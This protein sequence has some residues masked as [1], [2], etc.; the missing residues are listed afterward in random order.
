MADSSETAHLVPSGFRDKS[1]G[2]QQGLKG[3]GV[4]PPAV[5]DFVG[6][7]VFLDVKIVD[8]RNRELAAPGRL[9]SA[10]QR[11]PGER[12]TPCRN[13]LCTNSTCGANLPRN[14]R[15]VRS[16]ALCGPEKYLPG[17][18]ECRPCAAVRIAP[19]FSFH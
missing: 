13:L 3:A 9:V 10:K 6:Q 11:P 12:A 19:G 4:G 16:Q 8:V 7:F 18:R 15:A 5:Q 2:A 1:I 17:N 14:E